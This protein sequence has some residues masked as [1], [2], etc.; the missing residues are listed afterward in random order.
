MVKGKGTAVRKNYIADDLLFLRLTCR[1]V[2]RRSPYGSISEGVPKPSKTNKDGDNNRGSLTSLP[3]IAITDE[4]NSKTTCHG[5]F[6]F[7]QIPM[8]DDYATLDTNPAG[9]E[10]HEE[11]IK[12]ICNRISLSVNSLNNEN[13]FVTKVRATYF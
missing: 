9:P 8:M 2:I 4:V 5:L 3:V 10:K 6:D 1:G 12:V 11:G 7:M 13:N